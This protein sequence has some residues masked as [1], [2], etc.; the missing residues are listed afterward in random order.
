[1]LRKE[2]R[3]RVEEGRGE[4]KGGQYIFKK[5]YIQELTML[6]RLHVREKALWSSTLKRGLCAKGKAA[7][8]R[9]GHA[10]GGG[11]RTRV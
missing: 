4:G 11:P 2:K 6:K 3:R 5:K 7:R 9:E 10:P 1:M 8:N